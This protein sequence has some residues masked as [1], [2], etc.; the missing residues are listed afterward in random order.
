MTPRFSS[1]APQAARGV[2][3][4]LLLGAMLE[5][6]E[7]ASIHEWSKPMGAGPAHVGPVAAESWRLSGPS[8][9]ARA[10]MRTCF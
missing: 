5:N 1:K 8:L 3:A 10:N 6:T 9:E 7:L 2:S 4:Q